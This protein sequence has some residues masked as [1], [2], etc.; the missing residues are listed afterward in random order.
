MVSFFSL[1]LFSPKCSQTLFPSDNRN[2]GI[3]F[4]YDINLETSLYN[5]SDPEL[6]AVQKVMHLA[7]APGDKL[8]Q[9]TVKPFSN[10]YM[11][12]S[13]RELQLLAQ[14]TTSSSLTALYFS[15]VKNYRIDEHHLSLLGS[16]G[17][18]PASAYLSSQLTRAPVNRE[19]LAISL[20][21]L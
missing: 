17:C 19:C 15:N 18:K 9:R 14:C 8:L 5:R 20:I 11:C 10:S 7:P 3:C 21:K 2:S 12:T 4:E 13:H 1:L 6:S 16:L